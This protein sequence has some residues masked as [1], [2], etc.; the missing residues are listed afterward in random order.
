MTPE[1]MQARIRDL[2]DKL[3]TMTRERDLAQRDAAA[4]YKI[5]RDHQDDILRYEQA[6]RDLEAATG[7][8]ESDAYR[9]GFLAGKLAERNRG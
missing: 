9:K 7:L 4:V 5:Q 3:Y 2:E 1:E 6:Y 8:R